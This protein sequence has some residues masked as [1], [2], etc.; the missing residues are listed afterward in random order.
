MFGREYLDD[1][2]TRHPDSFPAVA[3]LEHFSYFEGL[4]T[5][6]GGRWHNGWGSYL[7]NGQKYE[8]QPETLRKQEELYRY[9]MTATHALEIGVYLGHS[10]LI[11]LIA[12]PNLKITCIDN[13]DQFARPAVEYLNR[14]FNNRITFIHDDAIKGIAT[15]PDNTFDFVHIDADHYDEAVNNQ[16]NA[17]IRVAKLGATVVFDDY[18]AVQ[19]TIDGFISQG[20]LQHLVTPGCLWTNCVTRLVSKDW[21]DCVKNL[22]RPFTALSPERL[23]NNIDMIERMNTFG[24]AGDVVEVG[25]YKGGSMLAFLK[26]HEHRGSPGGRTFHLYDTFAGMTAPTAADVD[27]NGYTAT[28]LMEQNADVKCISTLDEVKKNITKNI[29]GS[30]TIEYHVGDI[31]QN[32]VYPEKIAILRL[33]TDWYESTAFELANF[34]DRVVPGGAVIIDDYGHWMGCKRAVDEFLAIH[35][36]IELTKIDYTGVYWLKPSPV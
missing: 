5:A 24:V 17:S 31:L 12:N 15:L 9:A 35:P 16:F 2:V 19:K 21:V 13:D 28:V 10:L 14:C 6:V 33:D 26:A 7:F 8:Y 18:E 23:Q 25:V 4:Y 22:C 36:E 1:I 3:L 30:N 27:L 29:S 34:Y 11:M 32:T 20:F